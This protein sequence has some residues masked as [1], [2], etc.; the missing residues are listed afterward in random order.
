MGPSINDVIRE[1]WGG[2]LFWPKEGSLRE[3]VMEEVRNAT[4]EVKKVK[5]FVKIE[6][7]AFEN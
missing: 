6:T 3:F 2:Y 7:P 1:G 5:E 4:D